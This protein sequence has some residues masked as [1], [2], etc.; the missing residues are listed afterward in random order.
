MESMIINRSVLTF[1]NKHPLSNEYPCVLCIKGKIF[2]CAEQAYYYFVFENF[3]EIADQIL[4]ANDAEE[5][6]KVA[7]LYNWCK[8]YGGSN[9]LYTEIKSQWYYLM[10]KYNDVLLSVMNDV[11]IE[12]F[13]IQ[14]FKEILLKTDGRELRLERNKSALPHGSSSNSFSWMWWRND[15]GQDCCGYLGFILSG[16][17]SCLK[18][19]N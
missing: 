3:V 17:R 4:E 2:N 8:T 9:H 18:N 6:K 11:L 19:H 10:K 1:N 13:K 15:L 5:A 12:K 7:S 14:E 16:I